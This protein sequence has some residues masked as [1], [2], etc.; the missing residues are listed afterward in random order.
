MAMVGFRRNNETCGKAGA[1]VAVVQP[2]DETAQPGRRISSL[3]RATDCFGGRLIASLKRRRGDDGVVKTRY[4]ELF[5]C[6]V[7]LLHYNWEG[8]SCL[9]SLSWRAAKV[10]GASKFMGSRSFRRVDIANSGIITLIQPRGSLTTCYLGLYT[11]R[12]LIFR[13]PS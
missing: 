3:G 4:V 7:L 11:K 12:S 6:Y 10:E 5:L 8:L 2:G 1:R 9:R 13:Y